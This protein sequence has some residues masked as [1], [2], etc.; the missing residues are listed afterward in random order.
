MK[1]KFIR[2]LMPRLFSIST[3]VP[4]PTRG[5]AAALRA[6]VAWT[7]DTCRTVLRETWEATSDGRSSWQHIGM[8][9]GL[10]SAGAHPGWCAGS[11][12]RCS[13]PAHC[14]RSTPCTAGRTCLCKTHSDIRNPTLHNTQPSAGSQLSA[15]NCFGRA[16]L[17][18]GK[19]VGR[20]RAAVTLRLAAYQARCGQRGRCA[21]TPPHG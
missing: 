20:V 16:A 5:T 9:R 11:R 18:C 14:G 4:A 3:T 1:S 8:L 2:S 6:V 7:P 10:S 21:A 12:A 13:P 19:A 15:S 17:I